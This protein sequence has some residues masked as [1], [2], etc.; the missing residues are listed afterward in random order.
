MIVD[1]TRELVIQAKLYVLY[2]ETPP[3]ANGYYSSNTTGKDVENQNPIN[4]NNAQDRFQTLGGKKY[5]LNP[6][7]NIKGAPSKKMQINLINDMMDLAKTEQM[8]FQ[9]NNQ[10]FDLTET[11]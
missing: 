7:L 1:K 11:I 3:I 4:R 6:S 9:L 8:K 5:N 10:F 2:N